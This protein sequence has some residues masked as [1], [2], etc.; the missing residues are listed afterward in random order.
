[1]CIGDVNN[2]G[3]DAF[4][5]RREGR[6]SRAIKEEEVERKEGEINKRRGA[7]GE[8]REEAFTIIHAGGCGAFLGEIHGQG[9]YE[10]ASAT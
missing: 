4:T 2:A 6:E 1:M 5:V 10:S 7:C 8:R 3:R 9:S